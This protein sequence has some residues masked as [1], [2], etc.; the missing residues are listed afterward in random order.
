[1]NLK[2]KT[3]ITAGVIA[4]SVTAGSVGGALLFTP[5]LS[6]AQED[7]TTTST[8]APFQARHVRRHHIL[9]GSLEVA[10]EAL[11]MD[12]AELREAMRDGKTIAD[13]AEEEGVAIQT[14]IDA[15]VADATEKLEQLEANLPEKMTA[16]VN[17]EL[18]APHH[19]RHRGGPRH[20]GDPEPVA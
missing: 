17:G 14:V 9:G 15:L 1:M 5:S 19:G 12:V 13:V 20:F 4:A 18:P 7:G 3:W 2:P 6:G 11:G 8:D 10:A 16:L